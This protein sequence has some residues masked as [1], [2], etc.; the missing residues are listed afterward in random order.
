MVVLIYFDTTLQ[1][2]CN[3]WTYI[4]WGSSMHFK[5]SKIDSLIF[6]DNVDYRFIMR[7]DDQTLL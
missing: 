6:F 1:V 2:Y 4:V 3:F 5:F 7:A